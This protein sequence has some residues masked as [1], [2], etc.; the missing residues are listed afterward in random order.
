MIMMKL[1]KIMVIAFVFLFAMQIALANTDNANCAETIQE[2]FFFYSDTCPHCHEQMPLMRS[3]DENNPN[4][5]VHFFEI[6][7]EPKK[8]DAIR[9]EYNITSGAVPRTFV[10]NHTFIGYSTQ[11][12][13]LEYNNVYKGNIGYKNQ[14]VKA[15]EEHIGTELVL[16]EEE[17]PVEKMNYW[18]MLLPLLYLGTLLFIKKR[19]RLWTAGFVTICIIAVFILIATIP[20]AA[21]KTFAESMPFPAFVFIIALADGFNPCAFTVLIILLS[22]LTYTKS[23]KDMTIIGSVFIITSAIMYFIFIMIMIFAGSIFI[24]KYGNLVMLALGVIIT[25]AGAINIKDYFFFKQ[26]LSLT[27]SEKQQSKITKKASKIVRNLKKGTENRKLFFAAIGGTVLLAIFVNIIELGCTAILPSVYMATLMNAFGNSINIM[28]ISWT[29]FYSGV[30]I[31]P[32]FVILFNFIYSFKSA[33][34]NE[35]QGKIL[36]LVSGLF[37]VIFGLLMIFKPQMLMFG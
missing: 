15:I 29:L 2:V 30:Y 36:K 3:I 7:K 1:L 26:G 32:L 35:N 13:E 18:V 37:M 27:L 17:M 21:I 31:L 6:S 4:L 22:L 20:D 33:R 5:E 25:V 14:I 12:G 28:H 11:D 16:D 10:H 8:W 9:A 34:I 19:T 24:E 23:R